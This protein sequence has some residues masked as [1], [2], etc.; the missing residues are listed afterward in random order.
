M[1]LR[2]L[3][4]V[5]IAVA[6]LYQLSACWQ[7]EQ[8]MNDISAEISM[9]SAQ[10]QERRVNERA[11]RDR[12]R[13][14]MLQELRDDEPSFERAV[15]L[16]GVEGCDGFSSMTNEIALAHQR[17]EE[18][19]LSSSFDLGADTEVL[20][21]WAVEAVRLRPRYQIAGEQVFAAISFAFGV[22]EACLGT[23]D[24]FEQSLQNL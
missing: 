8:R 4:L 3:L 5:F 19:P 22:K 10:A 14:R 17:E 23:V 15:I 20:Y 11:E 18:L 16:G 2:K 21:D 12:K 6:S 24:R 1:N 7:F 13:V 9:V